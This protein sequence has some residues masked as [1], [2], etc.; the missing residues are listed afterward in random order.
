MSFNIVRD[1]P[2]F[3]LLICINDYTLINF[4]PIA[5]SPRLTSKLSRPEKR[6]SNKAEEKST[7][8]PIIEVRFSG[9]AAACC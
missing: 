3:L 9:S 6:P 2:F 7:K 5:T 8:H 1:I 4:I